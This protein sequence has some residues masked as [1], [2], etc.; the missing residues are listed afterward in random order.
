[1]LCLGQEC[2]ECVLH[3][4][5]LCVS[6]WKFF[7]WETISQTSTQSAWYHANDQVEWRAHEKS[8][9]WITQDICNA[10]EGCAV[11]GIYS[12]GQPKCHKSTFHWATVTEISS[13]EFNVNLEEL[14]DIST[15]VASSE[16]AV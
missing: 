1:M 15:N 11:K 13:A 5:W 7:V 14:V 2:T 12:K 4:V 8:P 6:I 16:N 3:K 10:W 9:F